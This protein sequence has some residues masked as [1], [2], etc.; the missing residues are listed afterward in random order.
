M[1]VAP[2]LP[3]ATDVAGTATT[4][5]SDNIKYVI[6][7][8]DNQTGSIN[9]IKEDS[10]TIVDSANKE[11][12]PY[13]IFE[14][15]S[16]SDSIT[17]VK[18]KVKKSSTP[19]IQNS[20]DRTPYFELNK[21]WYTLLLDQHVSPRETSGIVTKEWFGTGLDKDPFSIFKRRF[22]NTE[23][24]LKNLKYLFNLPPEDSN[25]NKV[26]PEI[27]QS[28]DGSFEEIQQALIRPFFAI[29]T[30]LDMKSSRPVTN[31]RGESVELFFTSGRQ[32]YGYPNINGDK[33]KIISV[34]QM[35]YDTRNRCPE[36]VSHDLDKL[37]THIYAQHYFLKKDENEDNIGDFENDV[38]KLLGFTFDAKAFN[39]LDFLRSYTTPVAGTTP[40]SIDVLGPFVGETSLPDFSSLTKNLVIIESD[41][42]LPKS[43]EGKGYK[44]I[45]EISEL[46]DLNQFVYTNFEEKSIYNDVEIRLLDGSSLQ[47]L[48]GP[49]K[50]SLY[51]KLGSTFRELL[52]QKYNISKSD[53]E[54]TLRGNRFINFIDYFLSDNV[55][56]NN[57]HIENFMSQYL[58]DQSKMD[59][60]KLIDTQFNGLTFRHGICNY[61]GELSYFTAA[62]Q[63]AYDCGL[64][65]SGIV[66]SKNIFADSSNQVS[67]DV[68]MA[69][70]ELKN[71]EYCLE[72]VFENIQTSLKQREYSDPTTITTVAINIPSEQSVPAE[73]YFYNYRICADFLVNA[74]NVYSKF[75]V[76]AAGKNS[77]NSPEFR[78]ENL[79]NNYFYRRFAYNVLDL[80]LGAINTLKSTYK[81]EVSD[82]WNKASSVSYF[83]SIVPPVLLGA[84]FPVVGL[85][86]VGIGAAA[87]VGTNFARRNIKFQNK[88]NEATQQA[89][90]EELRKKHVDLSS[91]KD[92]NLPMILSNDCVKIIHQLILVLFKNFNVF[93][94]FEDDLRSQP[95]KIAEFKND[96]DIQIPNFVIKIGSLP[97]EAVDPAENAPPATTPGASTPPPPPERRNCIKITG[98]PEN[99]DNAEYANGV[100]YPYDLPDGTKVYKHSDHNKIYLKIEVSTW[101]IYFDAKT[102][103]APAADIEIATSTSLNIFTGTNWNLKNTIYSNNT[104]IGTT[105]K[106]G[107]KSEY[108]G[109]PY[110]PQ[111]G[112]PVT[113]TPVLPTLA[114]TYTL[115]TTT[116]TQYET[117]GTIYKSI[118]HDFVY[119]YYNHEHKILFNDC[120]ADYNVEEPKLNTMTEGMFPFIRLY[121][122]SDYT[123]PT[124]MSQVI[125]A[126]AITWSKR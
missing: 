55:F 76:P 31:D 47:Y 103:T 22:Y 20:N 28:K 19:P 5:V 44:L 116:T 117:L 124:D 110:I 95:K 97:R 14:E 12:P 16:N 66:Y 21:S 125:Y 49:N 86:T 46:R 51:R 91:L 15:P 58:S 126:D 93:I 13:S 4:T 40:P 67:A 82:E 101:Q 87:F 106:T 63:L 48:A 92:T 2:T 122:K 65:K 102:D 94:D 105:L 60:G 42:P 70:F 37:L 8:I 112:E 30:F 43:I 38:N 73:N 100:Y 26:F 108:I 57:K 6:V 89:L 3:A 50:I 53:I 119:K 74:K 114:P 10:D 59:L 7:G 71:I 1:S 23:L 111:P 61:S 85:T 36:C 107:I 34:L 33:S 25:F 90:V 98:F 123:Y 120:R 118:H 96:K 78:T 56:E 109:A 11:R 84:I 45:G 32:R 104:D 113:K 115:D 54:R 35:L 24:V 81:N 27:D 69:E 18:F 88:E 75:L 17:Y 41:K 80:S 121:R 29:K 39:I 62:M 52:E 72:R 79:I 9:Y 83:F 77:F 64:Y 99:N 68:R